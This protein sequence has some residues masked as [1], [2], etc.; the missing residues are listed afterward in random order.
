M[1]AMAK[2]GTPLGNTG[3]I[4]HLG[5][6]RL[7]DLEGELDLSFGEILDQVAS[8]VDLRTIRAC[9]RAGLAKHY[10]HDATNAVVNELVDEVG[11]AALA[12]AVV[13]EMTLS[14][15]GAAARKKEA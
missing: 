12:N 7:C 11:V 1:G 5:N 4:I 10:P 13:A 6:A 9:V 8:K 14:M 2:I 15:S 3:K